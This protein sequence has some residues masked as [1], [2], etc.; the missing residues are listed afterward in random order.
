MPRVNDSLPSEP[1][2]HKDHLADVQASAALSPG[3][4]NTAIGHQGR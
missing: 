3:T 2:R 4:G 1:A